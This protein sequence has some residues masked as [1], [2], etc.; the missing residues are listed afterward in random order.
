[1]LKC[2]FLVVKYQSSHHD[3]LLSGAILDFA[4]HAQQVSNSSAKGDKES[5]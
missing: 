4:F 3:L 1:V 2:I 5:R